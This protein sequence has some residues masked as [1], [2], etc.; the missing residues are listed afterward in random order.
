MK[1]IIYTLLSVCV[2]SL[3]AC[4]KDPYPYITLDDAKKID[5]LVHPGIKNVA[6]IYN[7]NVYYV[8]DF[9]KP[10]VQITKDGSATSLVKLSHDH[11]KFAYLSGPGNIRIVDNKGVVLTTLSQYSDVKT[12]DWSAD[13]KTLWI[14]N[15]NDIT[16]Y[17]PNMKLPGI[18]FESF[19]KYSN[20]EILSASVSVNGD[21]AYVVKAF[22]FFTGTQYELIIERADNGPAIEYRPDNFN[23]KPD[24]VSFSAHNQ[25]MVLGY[26]DINTGHPGGAQENLEFFTDLNAYPTGHYGAVPSATPVYNSKLNYVVAAGQNKSGANVPAALYLGTGDTTVSTG[27]NVAQTLFLD[28]FGFSGVL[29]IDWK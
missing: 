17:G 28:K 24:Y 1:K 5:S 16:F 12:F 3:F 20:Q 6:F 23:G 21:L 2:V 25:D 18:S 11:T 4:Q 19:N 8:D 9:T 14:L 26:V 13:D 27:A 22:D 10:V 15:G 7:G 29:Y